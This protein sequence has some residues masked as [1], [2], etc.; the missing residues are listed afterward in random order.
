MF[1]ILIGNTTKDFKQPTIPSLQS[2]DNNELKP[3]EVVLRRTQSFESDE[4]LVSFICFKIFNAHKKMYFCKICIKEHG[5]C[6][7]Y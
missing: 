4:K 7:V 6:I 3:P 5:S 2:S 1:V